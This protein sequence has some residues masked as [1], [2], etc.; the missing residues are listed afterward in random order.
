MWICD[1]EKSNGAEEG[2]RPVRMTQQS[3]HFL[4]I[5]VSAKIVSGILSRI[6]MVRTV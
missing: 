4:K 2:P 1:V 5:W 6:E 3:G